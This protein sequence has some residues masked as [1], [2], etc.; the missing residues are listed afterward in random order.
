M[1]K[2]NALTLSEAIIGLKGEKFSSKELV[3]ACLLRLGNLENKL[4][5]FVAINN[6]LKNYPRGKPSG[7]QPLQGIPIAI[8]DNFNTLNQKT[9]ASSNILKNYYPPFDAT[10]VVKLK[11][12]GALILGKTNMDAFAHGSS[13]EAS[14]FGPTANPWNLDYLPGGSSGG[15][16]AAVASDEVLAGIGS[17]TAGSIRQPASWCGVVGFKPTYG[18]ISR[19]GLIAMASSTDCPGPITK[20]VWD[21]AFIYN[22]LAGFDPMDATSSHQVASKP[23]LNLPIKGLKIGLPKEYFLAEAQ[24]GV[25]ATVLQAAKVLEKLGAKLINISLFSPKHSI[26]V[27]TILQRSEVSSNLARFDGV[28]FGRSRNAFNDEN[29][30]RI[31]LGTYT[32]SSGYYDAY[33]KKAQQVR[34]VIINDFKRIFEEVDLV[35][36][37]TSPTVALK[38]GASAGQ[39]MFGELQDI[40]VEASTIAG[41]PGISIP[42]GFINSLPVGLQLF[43]PAWSEELIL[44]TAHQFEQNTDWHKQKPKLQKVSS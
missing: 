12:A 11:K 32:L 3:E 1:T 26:S 39:T 34:T 8:K 38:K 31:I 37:P 9:T 36:A 43:G 23:K 25:N 10:V 15:S 29:R 19:Y 2:L 42:C 24:K 6:N 40:L 28:R 18:R 5:A 44:S 14:D 17:E 41:L 20:S 7:T 33:Y 27:Y 4:H 22:L 21:A 35:L 13:T 16:A 30:R